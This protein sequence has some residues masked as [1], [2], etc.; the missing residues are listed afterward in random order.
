MKSRSFIFYLFLPA[1]M[2]FS[3]VAYP[4]RED[5]R[6]FNDSTISISEIK[7]NSIH[8]DFGPFVIQDTLFFTTFNDKLIG[9]TDKSLRNSEFYDLYKSEIDKQGNVIG[10]RLPVPEFATQFNDGPVSWC[11]KTG[12]LFITQNYIDQMH[13]QK[14]K[15]TEISKLKIIIAKRINGKWKSISEFPYNN[16]DY[17][18][19]HPAVTASGDT[20]VFSSD[21]PGGFGETDLYFSVRTNGKWG[22]PVNFGPKINT[23]G[24]EEFAFLT[25]R[26]FTKQYLIFSSK[27]RFG[28]GG[29]D[30]YYT[31]YPSEYD[32][33][34]HFE[35]PLN[36]EFDDFAMTIPT[37]GEYGYLTSNRPGTGDD[38]IYKFKFKKLLKTGQPEQPR[39]PQEKC[40]ALYVYDQTSRHPIPGVRIVSCD[41]QYFITDGIGKVACLPCSAD[42]C[43]VTAST[44]GY[45]DKTKMLLACNPES[46]K[47][48]IDT[49]W[50][51][52]AVNAKITLKNIYYDFDKWDIL[53]ESA[54]ELDQ[55]VS[56]MNQNPGMKVELGSHTDDRGTE[57]Y[58]M[59]LSHLRAQSAVDYIVSKGIDRT[60][61]KG[62]GYGKSQLI[63]KASG[64]NKCT[65]EQNRE[66]RRTE[67]YIPG[68][69][70]G[71]SVR[72]QSGDYSNGKPDASK[73]YS[74]FKEHGN[75]LKTDVLDQKA[76]TVANVAGIL[77]YYL[78]L[79]SFQTETKAAE[80][81]QQL[82]TEG[83]QATVLREPG[84][85]RIG[86]GFGQLSE[87]KKKLEILKDKYVG[88]WILKMDN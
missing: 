19:G 6:I 83:H 29:F 71:E 38:D 3:S 57:I 47:M 88:A 76:T 24:K 69:L 77:K 31:I 79:G 21:R 63:H 74:S 26:S 27:G 85:Y 20:L 9:K 56:L 14:L 35:N 87:A 10:K 42:K 84:K 67:I 34:G 81:V 86:I 73:E 37:N 41:W 52:I 64:L 5:T 61:I 2:L 25:G 46:K 33:I 30:L 53:A 51:D 50:M 49:I 62:T 78:I 39:Q 15:K 70:R 8:S 11:P 12:E 45:P 58:N 66:N 44:F 7:I 23:S 28:N 80:L 65:P 60:R 55:L 32:D 13:K 82:N 17:S 40:R 16:P 59:K 72:Q 36:T 75:L 68:F 48:V 18:V 43:E 54:K 1:L 4:Q 22:I